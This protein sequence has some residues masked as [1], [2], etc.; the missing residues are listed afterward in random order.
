MSYC[1]ARMEKM[2]SD[3]LVGIGN[4]NQRRFSNHSNKDI[5]V[6]KSHLNYDILDKVKSYKTD[7]EGYINANKSSKRAVR[8]DAVLVCEWIITSDSDFFESMS[9]AD[10]REY[11]Q[12]AIDFFAE[13]YGSKNLMYAQVHLDERTPHMHLGIVPFDK[14]NKLTAKTMFD[15][16]ALQDIQNEL[17]R[18]MNERGFEVERGRA[19]SEAKHLTVQEYKDVQKEIK[20]QSEV[21]DGV[22]KELE[23]VK[24]VTRTKDFL[25]EL[26]SKSKKT[27]LGNDVKISQKDYQE[28]KEQLL[29]ADKSLLEMDK[30]KQHNQKLSRSIYDLR[31]ELD[32]SK[33]Y[34]D[35][36]YDKN[37]SLKE[38]IKHLDS[39]LGDFEMAQIAYQDALSRELSQ[40]EIIAR[41]ICHE[42]ELGNIPEDES[43]I[44]YYIDTLNS[45]EIDDNTLKNRVEKVIDILKNVLENVLEFFRKF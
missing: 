45:V 6:S 21:L 24:N 20:K 33:A 5:D 31:D 23:S 17:P 40:D 8:K 16:E 12:T 3:N 19:G 10:T 38:Q 11:F 28:L 22:K 18:Y 4:H 30:L 32:D 26:D 35:R 43:D 13:R 39:S 37:D 27:L 9:P 25:D 15:R 36:L 42:V 44:E 2:K 29:G 7:I 41:Y 14:D 1:V 34:A